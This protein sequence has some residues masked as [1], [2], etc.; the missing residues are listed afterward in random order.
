M[1]ED[2]STVRE[3]IVRER[4]E[5]GETVRELAEKA[6]VKGRVQKKAA[7]SVGQVADKAGHVVEQVADKAGQVEDRVR[8]ATPE[9]IVSGVE[10]AAT[11]VRRRPIPVAAVILVAVA[12]ILG[13]RLR[14]RG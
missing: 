8:S 2:A 11:S 4:A 6:D 3:Q 12:L 14:R 10:N 13:W 1:G 5:L 9:P 7:E